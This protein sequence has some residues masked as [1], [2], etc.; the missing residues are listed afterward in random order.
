MEAYVARS[1]PDRPIL[2]EPSITCT[3]RQANRA[4]TFLCTFTYKPTYWLVTEDVVDASW[5]I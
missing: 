4:C 2:A 1:R 5:E 3:T